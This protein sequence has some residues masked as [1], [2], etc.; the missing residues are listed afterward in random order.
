MYHIPTRVCNATMSHSSKLSVCLYN[1]YM[2]SSLNCF[3]FLHLCP[4]TFVLRFPAFLSLRYPRL[5][6][7]LLSVFLLPLFLVLL[8]H[9]FVPFPPFYHPP[10]ILS[11]PSCPNLLFILLRPSHF[12][13]LIF[14][15]LYLT[16]SLL[17]PTLSHSPFPF[18]LPYPLNTPKSSPPAA[19]PSHSSPFLTPHFHLSALNRVLLGV[20]SSC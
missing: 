14:L 4:F 10:I 15:I 17:V 3:I 11:H 18:L 8:L 20:C 9:A 5:R 6:I 16:L 1:N 13:F 19:S 7:V 12:I 2:H